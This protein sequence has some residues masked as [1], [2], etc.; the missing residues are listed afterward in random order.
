MKIEYWDKHDDIEVGIDE[1]GW[2]RAIIMPEHGVNH[3]FSPLG[4][5]EPIVEYVDTNKRRLRRRIQAALKE[6]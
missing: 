2:K 1:N 4:T 3:G 5:V 6:L